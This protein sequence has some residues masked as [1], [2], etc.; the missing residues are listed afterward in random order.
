MTIWRRLSNN[1]SVRGIKLMNDESINGDFYFWGIDGCKGGWFCIG[2]TNAGDH[3]SLVAA[4]II[5]AHSKL[6]KRGAKIALIDIPIGLSDNDEERTCD[7]DARQ[8]IGPRRR[9]VF[10]VPCRQ[11]LKVFSVD[12]AEAAKKVNHQ[13]TRRSLSNQTL[14]IMKKIAEVDGFVRGNESKNFFREVHPEVCFW[15]LNGDVPLAHKKKGKDGRCERLEILRRYSVNAKRPLNIDAI[16]NKSLC[17]HPRKTVAYDDVLDALA[18]ALTAK[19]GYEKGYRTLP[20][21]PAKDSRG[22][23]MEMV[24]VINRP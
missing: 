23:T 21:A 5:D 6:Q 7:I 3:C 17:E 14:A 2:L 19:I 22:L 18:A 13:I 9:S 16:Y 4:D 8:C 12:G 10:R 1:L 11:A 24:C 20:T 15:A